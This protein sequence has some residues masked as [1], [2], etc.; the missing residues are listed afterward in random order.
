MMMS[1]VDETQREARDKIE[2]SSQGSE[3]D[4]AQTEEQTADK[5]GVKMGLGAQNQEDENQILLQK[6]EEP[7]FA[8]KI[9]RTQDEEL[10]EIAYSEYKLLKSL[11]HK[12]IIK[13]HDAFLNQLNGTMYLVMDM[14]NGRNLRSLM[15]EDR[16]RFTEK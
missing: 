8:V 15:E 9:I 13:M 6:E 3:N 10:I 4:G 14:A 7:K 11:E 16:V 5:T 2:V 1:P 12:N